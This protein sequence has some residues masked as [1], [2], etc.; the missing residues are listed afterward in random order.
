MI[1]TPALLEQCMMGSCCM[2]DRFEMVP[3]EVPPTDPRGVV[4]M[5]GAMSSSL[6]E[7]RLDEIG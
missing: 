2:D 3:R 7:N 5:D 4:N 6:S 1:T